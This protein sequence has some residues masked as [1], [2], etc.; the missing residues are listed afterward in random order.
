[1]KRGGRHASQEDREAVIARD[2]LLCCLCG[3]LG[4]DFDHA[5]RLSSALPHLNEAWNL[6]ILC[7]RC[8]TEVT[9]PDTKE[10]WSKALQVV[11]LALHRAYTVFTDQEYPVYYRYYKQKLS[12]FKQL[13]D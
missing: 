9:L 3:A 7:R 1:M 13:Y 8:H 4:V 2:G 12:R 6:N 10:K 5:I 11:Q